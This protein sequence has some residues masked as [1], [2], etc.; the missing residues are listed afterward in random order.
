MAGGY[1][2]CACRDCFEIAIAADDDDRALC[3]ACEEAGCTADSEEECSAPHAYCDGEEVT[4]EDGAAY[5]AACG[6]PF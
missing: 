4:G 2:N 1:V 3:S 5:C 6:G